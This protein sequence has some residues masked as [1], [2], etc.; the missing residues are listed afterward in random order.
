[1]IL[2][3]ADKR[4][5]AG[6]WVILMGCGF[7]VR[8]MLASSKTDLS[9]FLLQGKFL[10]VAKLILKGFVISLLGSKHRLKWDI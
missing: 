8:S 10:C 4:A 3:A 7:P 5:Y 6:H 9:R 1:V 2:P